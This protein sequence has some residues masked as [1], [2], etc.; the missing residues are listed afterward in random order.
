MSI[1]PLRARFF[2]LEDGTTITG[3]TLTITS[4]GELAIEQN[5]NSLGATLDGVGVE[6]YGNIQVDDAFGQVTL[7]LAGGTTITAGD[8]TI[9]YAGVVDVEAGSNTLGATLDGVSVDNSGVI[10]VGAVASGATLTL[11]DDAA[12]AN[13]T[14]TVNYGSALD[15]ETGSNGPGY[16]ATLENV[17]VWGSGAIQV[18]FG[19]N[20]A[21]LILSAGTTVTG[22]ALSISATGMVEI[23]SG[24]NNL[25]A[26]LDNV[27]VDNE[28]LLQVDASATLTIA[29]TVT[30]QGGGT[31]DLQT[32]TE[33]I[34]GT[35]SG[36]SSGVLSPGTL[37]NVDNTI[38]GTGYIGAGD[39]TLTLD[40]ET[41]GTVDA[42]GAGSFITLD[43]GNTIT[44]AGLLEATNGG[45][46]YIDDGVTNTGTG[47][48][49]AD[50]SS[51][52]ITSNSN[53]ISGA[54]QVEV[55]GAGLVD[56]ANA[57]TAD[58]TVEFMGAGTVALDQ[59]ETSASHV[60]LSGFAAGDSIDLSDLTYSTSETAIWTQAGQ[61]G[62]LAIDNGSQAPETITFDGNY[63]QDNFVV[64][65][66]A[67][68]TAL[69]LSPGYTYTQ[70]AYPPADM[71]ADSDKPGRS[72]QQCWPG[73]R[74]I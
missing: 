56:F 62:T 38:T 34:A 10:E 55:T 11:D 8:L 67:G 9:G 46:L 73:P 49:E 48:M 65:D 16:G 22:T 41:S 1:R 60:S 31:V 39:A 28:H 3:G 21:D 7:T 25:G 57:Q 40:N 20:G 35:I 68:A 36:D 58:V 53:G 43:T 12:I 29:D 54:G 50:G 59:S 14:L 26:V 70:L 15:I 61:S 33:Q 4:S 13:G 42:D 5:L 45:T 37:D 27:S 17:N 6:N 72:H 74:S 52:L 71:P 44:N 2:T 23:Q 64:V 18:D 69:A 63:S 66:D 19:Q 51:L 30:L 24:L 47:T 32:A